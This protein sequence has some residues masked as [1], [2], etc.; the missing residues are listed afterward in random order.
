[1]DDV[2]RLLPDAV[3]NQIAAGEVIQRPASVVK[4]L[5]ENAVDAHCSLITLIVKDA[6]RT[7]IQVVDNGIGMSE[8]DARMSFERHATS[9]LQKVEDL[10]NLHTMG[11]RGEALASIASIAQVELKTRRESEEL[12]TLIKIEGSV[13]KTQEPCQSEK[14]TSLTV[15]NL[16]F[17]VPARR[18]FLKSDQA[19]Y[20]HILDEFIRVALV[21]TDIN[22]DYY[23]DNKLLYSLRAHNFKQRI[24]EIFGDKMNPALL[25][26]NQEITNTKISGFVGKPEF[27]TKLKGDQYFFVNNRFI[28]HPY[29]HHAV[30]QAYQD[31]LTDGKV[32]PYFINIEVDPQN[33]DINI[34][35]TKTEVKF[36]EEKFIYGAL[37]ATIRKAI[38]T[39]TVKPSLDF[40]IDDTFIPETKFSNGNFHQNTNNNSY[41]SELPLKAGLINRQQP[42]QPSNKFDQ[43]YAN[44]YKNIQTYSPNTNNEL[45]YQDSVQS[46]VLNFFQ[47]QNSIIVASMIDY[48]LF[49]DQHRASKRIIYEETLRQLSDGGTSEVQSQAKLFKQT[50]DLSP[51]NADYLS[52]MK[53]DLKKIGWDI[54]QIGK[55]NFVINSAPADIKEEE[56]KNVLFVLL[57]TYRKG[58][59]DKHEKAHNIAIS[60]A[61]SSAIGRNRKLNTEEQRNILDRLF[62]CG[63]PHL[64]PTGKKVFIK[65][66]P[67]ELELKFE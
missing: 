36:L 5:L 13:V 2:V 35:P 43:S 3:A 30:M 53:E 65:L 28:K 62:Q 59:M 21:N 31:L 64:S 15:K 27:A 51:A 67:D 41:Q 37:L 58:I 66:L 48:V 57:D 11:F 17:N 55:M 18:Q 47:F 52:E 8:S 4:E 61:N 44:A 50:I 29:L 54:E 46:G 45:M 42:F 7:S 33:I 20:R 14:G 38:G 10:F 16:F 56:I 63:T 6:G 34:H 19:E 12:G 60:V 26:I 40:N 25:G 39:S 24:V 49:I 22:F 9:K 1:M 23:I 32:P